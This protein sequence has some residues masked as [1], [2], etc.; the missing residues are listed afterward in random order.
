MIKK[1]E[2]MKERKE[3]NKTRYTV[4]NKRLKRRN[5]WKERRRERNM[6]REE[7]FIFILLSFCFY[8]V[9]IFFTVECRDKDSL[10]RSSFVL[11]FVTS[12]H[13]MKSSHP[14]PPPPPSVVLATCGG[15]VNFSRSRGEGKRNCQ[16]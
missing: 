4:E 16:G 9:D 1:K 13:C 7:H 6:G 12:S 11:L 3:E 10:V 14:P 5:E 15:G 2:G 8:Q